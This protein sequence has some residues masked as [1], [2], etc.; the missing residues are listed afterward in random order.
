MERV[1][2]SCRNGWI[3]KASGRRGQRV[4]T[5]VDVN[6]S[7]VEVGGVEAVAARVA[8]DGKTGINATGVA[9]R[10]DASS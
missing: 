10:D 7:I 1:P 9:R 6:V 2:G 4:G 8:A 3:S 5:I